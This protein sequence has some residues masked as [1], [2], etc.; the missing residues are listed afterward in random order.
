LHSGVLMKI[1]VD[2]RMIN[3]S[4]V[5]RYLRSFFPDLIKQK[6]HFFYL[7]GFEDDLKDIKDSG[8]IEKIIAKKGIYSPLSHFEFVKLVP[9]CDIFFSPHFVAPAFRIKAKRRVITIHDVFH[10]SDYSTLRF[11]EKV[12]MRYLY[13]SSALRADDI[14][15][16]SGFSKS[17]IGRFLN[18]GKADITVIN[19]FVD[20]DNFYPL[21]DKAKALYKKDLFNH[22]FEFILYVGNIKPHKNLNRL[23]HAFS[24]IGDKSLHLVVVGEKENFLKKD[25]EFDKT[26]A[27][28]ERV[29]FTGYIDDTRLRALYNLA[30]FF[31]FPSFYEGFGL[32][33]LEAIACGTPVAVSDIPVLREVCGDGA[34]YFNPFSVDDIKEKIEIFNRDD[35]LRKET[36]LKGKQRLARFSKRDCIESHLKLLFG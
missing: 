14:I 1:A 3:K 22:D 23:I 26:L 11:F 10:I 5:G 35:N 33:P 16:V 34:I 4:G 31:V 17:E 12:Y 7:I 19:N 9:G 18:T 13:S 27:E 6:A 20:T 8:N 29:I 36:L 15:T 24:Q 30:K 32:P 25:S 28:T 21:D 2:I